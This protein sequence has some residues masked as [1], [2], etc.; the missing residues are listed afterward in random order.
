M[1][2]AKYQN[3]DLVRK[4]LEIKQSFNKLRD[5]IDQLLDNLE[6]QKNSTATPRDQHKEQLITNKISS[7]QQINRLIACNYK[8]IMASLGQLCED[9]MGKPPCEYAIAGMGSLARS[10]ITPY[11]DFEHIILLFDDKNYRSDLEYFRWYSVIFHT[12]ILNLQETII[13]S[14]NIDILNNQNFKFG[15][16]YFD[17]HTPQGI[18][19]DGMMPHASKFPLGRIQHTKDKLFQTELIKPVSQMLE[20]LGSKADLKNG[21]HLADILT[22]TCFVFG[23]EEVFKQFE[24]RVKI[25]LKQKTKQER[26]KEVKQQVK[27]DLDIYS[28]RFRLAKLKSSGKINIKQLIY[29]SISIFIAALGKIHNITANSSFEA[30]NEM[31]EI[32]EITNITRDK[33]NYA[34]AVAC[35]IRLKVYSKKKMSK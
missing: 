24:Y 6:V 32:G 28:T 5:E 23:N 34:I 2:D 20:Y 17:A 29:R 14:L 26:I 21:Y 15:D 9:V 35:E 30:V 22:K 4:A 18:S 7:V 33:L 3:A 10:E 11:S 16:W 27:D 8:Q 13:P 31:Q 1:A 25:Y 12:I 19:F